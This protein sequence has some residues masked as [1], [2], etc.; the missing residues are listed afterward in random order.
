MGG[1]FDY[2]I[3]LVPAEKGTGE[4]WILGQ[5]RKGTL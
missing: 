4:K 3:N 1:V 2:D 5:S